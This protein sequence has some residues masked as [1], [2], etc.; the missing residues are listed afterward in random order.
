[1]LS[2]PGYGREN[3]EDAIRCWLPES[4]KQSG[5]WDLLAL[6]A[7]GIGGHSSG[8]VA[9]GIA[10][11]TILRLANELDDSPSEVLRRSFTAA[12]AAIIERGRGDPACVGMGTTCT[13]LALSAG[14]LFLAHIG[15]S[16]AYFLRDGQ[17]RQLSEDDSLM[18]QM[19]RRGLLN[20]K[21][22]ARSRDRHILLHALG[23][24]E[25]P[26]L[27]VWQEGLPVQGGDAFLL[28]SDGL[29]NFVDDSDIASAI[30]A[31]AARDACNALCEAALKAG[32]TDNISLGVFKVAADTSATDSATSCLGAALSQ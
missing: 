32:G 13:L 15:D 17:L 20:E 26:A 7:D 16:R 9:S 5:M 27:T 4:G 3:N 11:E 28:C 21:E 23:T 8:E 18:A 19:V 2:H 29:T 12:N 31:M 14:A 6:V 24:E 30:A 10:A 1:M 25:I 22:A